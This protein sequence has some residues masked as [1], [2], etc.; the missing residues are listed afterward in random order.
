MT[1]QKLKR[2][3]L[4]IA[5]WASLLLFTLFTAGWPNDVEEEAEESNTIDSGYRPVN[6]DFVDRVILMQ[7][8]ITS[9]GNPTQPLLQAGLTSQLPNRWKDY[10]DREKSLL[11]PSD[12]VSA[13]TSSFWYKAVHQIILWNA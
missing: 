2:K 11:F 3:T 10:R 1:Y 4:L 7:A 8:S 5:V 12:A 6:S 13:C 9:E